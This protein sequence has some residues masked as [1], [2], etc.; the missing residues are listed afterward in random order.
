M[1]KE[2]TSKLLKYSAAAGA[3]AF[4]LSTANAEIIFQSSI[5]GFGGSTQNISD[6]GT[7]FDLD[8]DNN[9]TD[10]VGFNVI[11]AGVA[12]GFESARAF[13]FGLNMWYS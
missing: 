4:S 9:G 3:G 1:N 12:P 5:V 10:D 13:N 2:T 8:I 11:L 7:A 6:A